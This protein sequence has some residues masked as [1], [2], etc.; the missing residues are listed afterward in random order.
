MTV[1]EARNACDEIHNRFWRRWRK[2]R[3]TRH[4]PEWEKIHEEAVRLLEKYPFPLAEHMIRDFLDE[5]EERVRRKE[6]KGDEKT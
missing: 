6:G 5:L 1:E 4:S 2:Q 3:L